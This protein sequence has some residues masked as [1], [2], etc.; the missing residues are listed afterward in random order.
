[1]KYLLDTNAL[2]EPVR[3]KPNAHFMAHFA[4]HQS[5]LALA[6]VTWLEALY[7]LRRMPEGKRKLAIADYLQQMRQL[8]VLDFG[9][10]AAE[11]LAGELAR[12]DSQGRPAPLADGQIAAIAQVNGCVLVTSNTKDFRAFRGLKVEDW[13][14]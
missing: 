7:G 4:K 5:A 13:T 11:W 10:A 6:S 12:L 2:S 8:P 1:V 14:R 3:R 9:L